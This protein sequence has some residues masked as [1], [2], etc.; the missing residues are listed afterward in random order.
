MDELCLNSGSIGD[1][2]VGTMCETRLNEK[3][4][5]RRAN[6]DS[7]DGTFR[8]TYCLKLAEGAGTNWNECEDPYAII[9][10]KY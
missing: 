1:A 9:D 6:R 2:D 7:C 8:I 4:C 5:A 10:F 3:Q